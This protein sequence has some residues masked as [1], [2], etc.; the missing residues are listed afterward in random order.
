[1]D[2]YDM[3]CFGDVY[4]Q[5]LPLSRMKQQRY[6]WSEEGGGVVGLV[7]SLPP[8]DLMNCVLYDARHD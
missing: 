2:G 4:Q 3:C 5:L 8:I 1:M 6:G 7:P